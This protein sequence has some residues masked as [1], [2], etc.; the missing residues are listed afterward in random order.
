MDTALESVRE[1]QKDEEDANEAFPE[2]SFLK[3][4]VLPV[5]LPKPPAV[6]ATLES[7]PP[8]APLVGRCRLTPWA[9]DADPGSILG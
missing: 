7:C 9:V 2:P 8:P 1:F 4:A 6:L 3:D 5:G